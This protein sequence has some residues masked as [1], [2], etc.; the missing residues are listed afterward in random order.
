MA[1]FG[2]ESDNTRPKSVQLLNGGENLLDFVFL[3][4]KN[5]SFLNKKEAQ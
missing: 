5:P 3:I 1:H 4:R 2:S